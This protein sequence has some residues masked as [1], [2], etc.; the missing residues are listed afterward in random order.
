MKYALAHLRSC[1]TILEAYS[2]QEPLAAYLKKCFAANKKY[3]SKDRRHISALCYHYFRLGFLLQ[4]WAP[5][6]RIAAAHWLC[7]PDF[8]EALGP[9][10]P[11][12][13]LQAEQTR[14]ATDR[15]QMLLHS[16]GAS[17]ADHT[18]WLHLI[19]PAIAWESYVQS[20]L[21]QPGFFIRIR[22]GYEEI[23]KIKLEQ[24]RIN[25]HWHNDYCVRLPQGTAIEPWLSINKEV[26]VQ[27]ASSQAC[28]HLIARTIP[29]MEGTIWD[30]CAASGGKTILM[31]DVWG[32]RLQYFVSDIRPAILHNLERRLRQAGIARFHPFIADLSKSGGTKLPFNEVDVLLTDVPCT[33]SGTWARTP[34]QHHFFSESQL[35]AYTQRQWAIVH[36]TIPFL[37]K[38]GYHIYITCSVLHAENE[39]ITER[40]L[41]GFPELDLL[42]AQMID[43]T[44]LQADSMY[45]AIFK[46]N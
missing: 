5:E 15:L 26:V 36:N 40:T 17:L 39:A 25:A 46:K 41:Q 23:V 32:G 20:F 12:S 6:Q 16:F 33:G 2:G 45:I 44:A 29:Y 34:E 3:G 13:L 1:Q 11:T 31:H 38:G 14:H 30:A 42:H 9:L 43:G 4:D 10:L 8:P 28:G 21:Q 19:S 35:A 37:K 27:D 18:P 7:N 24:E 22:P